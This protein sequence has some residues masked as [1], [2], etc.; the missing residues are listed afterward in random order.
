MVVT[1][2]LNLIMLVQ[3]FGG[4]PRK[5]ILGARN[6][7][8]LARFRTTLK[9]G[10][11]YLWNGWRYSEL[12]KYLI[13]RDS[14]RIRQNKSGEVWSNSLRDLDVKSYPPRSTYSENHISATRGCCTPAFLHA[15][16][17]DQVL[18]AHSPPGMGVLFTIFF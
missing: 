1:T 16:E 5:K 12:D 14:F 8:N 4:P 18:L 6:M 17:S 3:N 2:R 11:E 10:G 13:Y 15:R 7:Q 9:F